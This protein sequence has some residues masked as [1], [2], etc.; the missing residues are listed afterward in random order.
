MRQKLRPTFTG[1]NSEEILRAEG[2]I[3]SKTND[4]FT[5]FSIME[6]INMDIEQPLPLL[7]R[8]E[9]SFD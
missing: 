7:P 6:P 5:F 2:T 3:G 9:F 4:S 1:K 8:F